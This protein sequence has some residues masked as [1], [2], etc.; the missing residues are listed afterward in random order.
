MLATRK[1]SVS[2][3]SQELTGGKMQ[4]IFKPMGNVVRDLIH[5]VVIFNKGSVRGKMSCLYNCC[6]YWPFYKYEEF[7]ESSED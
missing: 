1:K 6:T 5:V 3:E 7:P 4:Q 2:L